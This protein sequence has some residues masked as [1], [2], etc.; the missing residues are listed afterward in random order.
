MA[1]A[2]PP[3]EPMLFTGPDHVDEPERGTVPCA[4]AATAVGALA[5]GNSIVSGR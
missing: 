4:V 1:A 2:E 3:D 5:V